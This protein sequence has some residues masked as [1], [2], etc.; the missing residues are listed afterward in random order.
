LSGGVVVVV[1]C[2]VLVTAIMGGPL[3]FAA[4]PPGAM[5]ESTAVQ[6]AVMYASA[7]IPLGGRLQGEPTEVRGQVM[8]LKDA[9][10]F[11]PGVVFDAETMR[12][13]D[14]QVWL[15]AIKGQIEVQVEVAPGPGRPI[16]KEPVYDQM[17]IRMDAR[18]AEFMGDEDSPVGHEID[19]SSLP[20][21][22]LPTGSVPAP[23]PKPTPGPPVTPAPTRPP[24]S[25]PPVP[26][27]S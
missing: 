16:A 14:R 19:V 13:P 22:H 8:G 15:I 3:S 1:V 23:A 6:Q 12:Q 10:R 24:A 11:R 20:I 26:A 7:G 27:E 18:T 5:S 21:L 9:Q 17:I 2:A 25:P 4:G